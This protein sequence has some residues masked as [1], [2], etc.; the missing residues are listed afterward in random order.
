MTERL[1]S[2]LQMRIPQVP[3]VDHA[4]PDL[5]RYEYAARPCRGG[6]AH[7]IVEQRLCRTNLDKCRGQVLKVSKEN[8]QTRIFPVDAGWH[9][10]RGKLLKVGFVNEWIDGIPGDHRPSG[11]CEIGPGRHQPGATGELVASLLQPVE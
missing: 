3:G 5:E 9:V 10:G 1:A 7:R 11:H 8:R 2:F 4:R 6:E